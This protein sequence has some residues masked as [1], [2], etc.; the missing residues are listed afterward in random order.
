MRGPTSLRAI[1]VA[2]ALGPPGLE[3]I[4]ASPAQRGPRRE[5]EAHAVKSEAY[6]RLRRPFIKQFT[7]QR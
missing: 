5:N 7:A 1:F 6:L 3:G 4:N 2:A